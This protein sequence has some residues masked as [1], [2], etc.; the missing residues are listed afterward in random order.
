M[1]Q[2]LSVIIVL[3]FVGCGA[4]KRVSV[5]RGAYNQP[6][7]KVLG[8]GDSIS[9]DYQV[10]AQQG[11]EQASDRLVQMDVLR[12]MA[13][14]QLSELLGPSSF[15]KD[16]LNV[17]IG[18]KSATLRSFEKLKAFPDLMHALNAFS[19]GVNLLIDQMPATRPDLV[20]LYRELARNS[21]YR[22]NHWSPIDCVAM[23]ESMAF[24][25]STSLED[26]LAYGIY[27]VLNHGLDFE[28]LPKKIAL[29][30]DLR[31]VENVFIVGKGTKKNVPVA[32][33]VPRGAAQVLSKL[34][35]GCVRFGF[36]W[37]DCGK[38]APLGSNN[39]VVSKEFSGQGAS[40]LANDP[41]LPLTFPTMFYEMALDSKSAGGTI[42]VAG[43][44]VPGGPGIMI[45][46]NGEM[47]WGF[48]N[49]G[50]DVDDV[51]FEE[52]SE[53]G[54]HVKFG[55]TWVPLE[56][57]FVDIPV[58]LSSGEVENRSITLRWVNHE[59]QAKH[60]SHRRP[61]FSDHHNVLKKALAG[62][63]NLTG[64]KYAV[65]YRWVGHE[66]TTELQAVFA[67]NKAQNIDEM[68]QAI[69][70][71]GVGSQ[72]VV[73]A[74]RLGNIGYMAHG[75]FPVRP[76]LSKEYP[77]YVPIIG[78]SDWDWDGFQEEVPEEVNPS[79][80]FIVTANNDPW[81]DTANGGDYARY[82]SYGFSTGIRA[83]RITT[84]IEEG[85]GVL[86]LE[87][88]KQIQFDHLDLLAMRFIDQIR[89]LD[90]NLSAKARNFVRKLLRWNGESDRKRFEPVIWN[91]VLNE[92][93]R[94]YFGAKIKKESASLFDLEAFLH[95]HA[96]IKTLYHRLNE[97]LSS[98]GQ[99]MT[100][101]K[102]L[103]ETAL[104]TVA[105][106]NG[107]NR[108][109][110]ELNRMQFSTPLAKIFPSVAVY[111]LERDGTFDTVDV[112][113]GSYGPNFRLVMSLSES[114]I[115]AVNVLPGGNYSPTDTKR[116]YKELLMWRDG[117]YRDL[118]GWGE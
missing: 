49:L 88:M 59:Y 51:Y 104:E 58:R 80:G 110:G 100:D 63:E 114:G 117:K 9:A 78:H 90:L 69:R 17:A 22:P 67:M 30:F 93:L 7:I 84:L 56:E 28:N 86:S 20:R 3:S 89:P 87:R 34:K 32:D 50:A 52:L 25:L 43:L 29:Q 48:T 109:W 38:S 83:K 111:N 65:S 101:A 76:Y 4:S 96:V 98:S 68:R 31:P 2:I 62:V 36:P 115:S 6:S 12:R 81:G 8:A 70:Y 99:K 23:A 66:G 102:T 42:R 13:Q 92:M 82:L 47:G 1:N 74:D 97:G 24:F 46:H 45:G 112:A 116:L 72:N 16:A 79:R 41:H 85:K 35:V 61:I 57:E 27:G 108:V 94:S 5:I 118:I 18:L 103:W 91:Q 107:E 10:F 33:S 95:S 21:E 75:K 44:N 64:L 73:Y 106:Q 40:F 55:E 71:F 14:G 60:R 15:E 54:K 105:T 26:K 11:F 39:W 53:D 113:H 37:P 19:D 77:P